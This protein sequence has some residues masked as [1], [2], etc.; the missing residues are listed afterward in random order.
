MAAAFFWIQSIERLRKGENAPAQSGIQP[1]FA[2]A[3]AGQLLL[4]R[5]FLSRLRE[6]FSLGPR[7][8]THSLARNLFQQRIDFT[9]YEFRRRHRVNALSFRPS[10]RKRALQNRRSTEPEEMRVKPAGNATAQERT[11]RHRSASI[12][13][14]SKHGQANGGVGRVLGLEVNSSSGRIAA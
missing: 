1:S 7:Q 3:A 13:N 4:S 14:N 11:V 8:A 2:E 5:D 6:Q 12:E 9:R 10:L